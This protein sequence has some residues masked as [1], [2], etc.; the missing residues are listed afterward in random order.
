MS[1]LKE[2][3]SYKE[4]IYLLHN[5][6][7][8]T[9][10]EQKN[11]LLSEIDLLN[12]SNTPEEAMQLANEILLKLPND[13]DVLYLRAISATKLK[14]FDIAE[15]DLKNILEQNPNIASALNALG[16]TVSFSKERLPEA[17]GYLR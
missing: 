14:K 17:I 3:R 12:A 15:S 16:Y 11:L 10:V 4:A 8:S 1:L 7:P 5:S 6:T 9:N 13:A 2:T